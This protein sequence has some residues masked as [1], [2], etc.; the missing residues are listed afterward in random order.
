MFQLTLSE[1]AEVVANCD[2]LTRLKFSKSL[3]YAFTEHGAIQAA[4][5]L[6]SAQAIEMGYMWYVPLL[7]YVNCLSVPVS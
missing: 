4:N 6:A 7:S 1:K 5:V 2:H 3:P